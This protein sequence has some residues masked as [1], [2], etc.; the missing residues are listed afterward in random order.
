MTFNNSVQLLLPLDNNNFNKII[1][2]QSHLNVC[3]S[4]SQT[5]SSGFLLKKFVNSRWIDVEVVSKPE[6][7][8]NLELFTLKII[9]C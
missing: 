3:W 5:N 6:T 1:I 8:N 2:V 4:L 9:S 7:A